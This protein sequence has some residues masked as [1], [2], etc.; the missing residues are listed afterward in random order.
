M[1]YFQDSTSYYTSTGPYQELLE[2]CR[3]IK[4]QEFKA[5]LDKVIKHIHDPTVP[6][7][8][9]LVL[10]EWIFRKIKFFYRP[11]TTEE[12]SELVTSLSQATRESANLILKGLYLHYHHDQALSKM[13]NH[14]FEHRHSE[15]HFLLQMFNDVTVVQTTP[16]DRMLTH[17][18]E[19]IERSR[20]YE[21]QCNLLDVLLRYYK[22]DSRVIEI[23][24]K[25]KRGEGKST[26]EN[27][28]T[29]HQNAHQED[30]TEEVMRVVAE[31]I[32]WYKTDPYLLTLGEEENS[33]AEVEKNLSTVPGIDHLV[34]RARIDPTSFSGHTIM[35]VLVALSEYISI[36]PAKEL[37]FTR[38]GEEAAEMK[39][40]CSSGYITRMV[41]VLQGIEEKFTT[42][43]PF[44]EQLNA[45]ITYCLEK[46]FHSATEEEVMGS[47]QVE[48]REEYLELVKRSVNSNL[49]SI[50]QD[51]GE[52]D[53]LEGIPEVMKRVT[54]QDWVCEEGKIKV[55]K[56]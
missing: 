47:Y 30:I 16:H 35:N 27:L 42:R 31:L 55:K 44:R 12:V 4:T 40:L 18:L 25:M 28:Y 43:L 45:R 3:E 36:S 34:Y 8:I 11:R 41:N 50:I 33:I 48:Y 2:G 17:F 20:V 24:K 54:G 56:E 29:D 21:Q 19:W 9:K 26:F 7:E 46:A 6:L 53:V 22:R 13:A 32:K 15:E 14:F 10:G 23:E 37:L 38:L 39:G 1:S 52:K 51:Y 5:H 49:K